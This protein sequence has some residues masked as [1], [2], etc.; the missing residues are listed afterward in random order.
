MKKNKCR[1]VS[2]RKMVKRGKIDFKKW[3]LS[4]L[5]NI[6]TWILSGLMN[7]ITWLLSGLMNIITWILSRLTN[8]IKG[9]PGFIKKTANFVC[10]PQY[11]LFVI[12][13][14]FFLGLIFYSIILALPTYKLEVIKPISNFGVIKSIFN[15]E[16]IKLIFN[17]LVIKAELNSYK[18]YY[19]VVGLTVAILKFK[20][21][22]DFNYGSIKE[23]LNDT[24]G[25]GIALKAF[26]ILFNLYFLGLSFFLFICKG[27]SIGDTFINDLGIYTGLILF[28]FE[29]FINYLAF[30]P[31]LF[32]LMMVVIPTIVNSIGSNTTILNWNFLL[33]IFVT[34]IG[35]N[36]FEKCLV[37]SLVSNKISEENLILRKI[38][39]YIGVVFLYLGIIL[40]ESI[41]NSTYY[42]ILFTSQAD[43]I[44][45]HLRIFVAKSLIYLLVFAVYLG[46]EKKIVYLIFRF[47]YRNEKLK[48]P[49][50]VVMVFLDDNK[51]WKVE[52]EVSQVSNDFKA[53]SMNT[54]KD[55][56]N[57]ALYVKNNGDI[58]E[59]LNGL[60]KNEGNN[61][62]GVV[63]VSTIVLFLIMIAIIPINSFLDRQ[64][65]VDDGIYKIV[66]K[67]DKTDNVGEIIK[68]SGDAIVY[69]GKV[70]ALDKRTQSFEHGT[71][72]IR[73]KEENIL[74]KLTKYLRGEKDRE[75]KNSY[76]ELTINQGEKKDKKIEKYKKI[77]E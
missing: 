32:I 55:R 11:S 62:I 51:R 44:I 63:N 2:F 58:H 9:T 71:I 33:L 13:I 39:N 31:Y 27:L 65:R 68:V 66:E 56:N 12:E 59:K 49:D 5:M 6:I 20:S 40:S 77:K 17:Y 14:L 35:E 38:S 10:Y 3:L 72:S 4:G 34:I 74:T 47:Y 37:D 46:T 67:S 41:V 42:Y 18:L 73:K 61:I 64:V 54:Y 50:N 28:V 8:I 24:E 26:Y 36:F 69:K 53:I 76:I 23:Q 45:T 19:L 30:S 16:V 22:K 15:L 25:K 7:I 52:N 60:N 1:L 75:D 29:L 21:Q 43:P 57:G 70:E 48:H